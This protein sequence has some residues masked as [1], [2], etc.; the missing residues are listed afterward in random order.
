MAMGRSLHCSIPWLV[1]SAL[2]PIALVTLITTLAAPFA[3]H[4][5]FCTAY[6]TLVPLAPHA[7]LLFSLAPCG[8]AVPYLQLRSTR[9]CVTLA[10]IAPPSRYS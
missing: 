5:L 3:C 1:S 9:A 4:A 2:F 7:A 6:C 10:S 8:R